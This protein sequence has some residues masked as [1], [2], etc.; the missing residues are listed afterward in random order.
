[1]DTYFSSSHDLDIAPTNAA[2]DS[3]TGAEPPVDSKS[4]GDPCSFKRGEPYPE[5]VSLADNGNES[6]GYG[7]PTLHTP[8]DAPPHRTNNNGIRR[9]EVEARRFTGKENIE[10]YLLQFELTSKRNK[11]D[12]A[13]KSSALLCALDGS[14]RGL[15]S[16]LEDPISASYAEV[17]EALLR[18]YGPT[19]LVEVHE[20]A[21]SLLRL[22]KGQNIRELAQ[23]IQR[24]VKKAYPDIFGPP[25]ER[26]AVKHLISAVHEKDAIFYLRE[27]D[28]KDVTQTCQIYERYIALVSEDINTRRSGVRGINDIR[29]NSQPPP[30][31]ADTP[32]LQ[33]QTAEAIELITA[34]TNAQ[35]QKLTD[36][37]SALTT[38]ARAEHI[39]ASNP[40]AHSHSQP[41]SSDN[42]PPPRPDVPRRP[43]P[44]CGLAGHWA[45]DCTQ[46][47]GPPPAPGRPLGPCFRCKQPGHVS[48]QCTASLNFLG[49]ALAPGAGTRPPHPQ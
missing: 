42:I 28:P 23:E 38:P 16:E 3:V 22:Q 35:L 29:S 27:K 44:R 19:K 34:T 48:S 25:R 47:P 12:D 32:S 10:E 40:A 24:L 4:F 13:E 9:K 11:W 21:L 6:E 36:V 26:L 20:Q 37:L 8:S 15:F 7:P 43:C 5:T 49:P 46:R 30:A 33:R 18:R 17:K 45:R 31:A 41:P 2:Y 39:N 14:A 1:M